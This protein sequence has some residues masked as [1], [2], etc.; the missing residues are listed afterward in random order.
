[1]LLLLAAVHAYAN[2]KIH[3][4]R[5]EPPAGVEPPPAEWI[6]PLALTPE[7]R[8]WLAQNVAATGTED[9]RMRRLIAALSHDLPLQ[10]DP[11]TGTA[12]EV[13]STSRYNCLGLTHLVVALARELGVDAYYVRIEEFR[14][15]SRTG[16]SVLSSTHVAAGWGTVAN[17]HVIELETVSEEERKAADR[18]ADAAA[19]ALHYNNRAAELLMLGQPELATRWLDAGR[20][21]DPTLPE[22]WVNTGVAARRVG[23]LGRAEDAFREAI[24]I[25]PTHLAAYRN[26]A[27]LLDARGD[28]D[29]AHQLLVLAARPSNDNPFTWVALGDATIA[30][31][32]PE[33]AARFYRRAS[34][35]DPGN[36]AVL[37]ARAELALLR[38]SPDQAKRL[39]E[40]ALRADPTEARALAVRGRSGG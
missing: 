32:E 17:V 9:Q 18:I 13:F 3:P 28:P 12:A 1:M 7:M 39:A 21:V 24:R 16:A 15:Y 23:D 35:I 40:R 11:H 10:Y 36:A 8:A 30:I 27:S 19:V 25:A 14:S 26:L 6:E 22:L 37:A 31:G 33:H 4:L 34:M 2:S 29:A 20:A 5:F 38:G